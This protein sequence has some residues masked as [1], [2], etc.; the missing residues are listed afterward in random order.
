M[1]ENYNLEELRTLHEIA[2]VVSRSAELKDQLQQTLD[3]LSSR[4]G[5]ERGMVSVLD[6]QTGEAW[7]DVARG[8][9][10]ERGTIRYRP[11]EGITGK[12]AQSGR[13]MGIANLGDEALFLDRTGARRSLNR[14]ELAFLCV[15]IF[16]QGRSVGVLSA[17]KLARRVEDLDKEVEIL[18]AVA[19]LLGK[20][21]HFR[22]VEEENSRLRRMLAEARRPT[23]NII[24]RSKVIQEVLRAIDQVA[25]TNTTVLISGETGTGKELVARAIH[26][27]SR[28]AKGPLVQVNCAAMPDTLLES[29][30]FGHEK[31]AFTG[32]V[33]RR[34]GRFEE[35]QGG[36]IFLDEVGELS[37]IAQAKLLRVLQEREFQP[38]G[39]SRTVKVDVRVITAS[40][41]DLEKEV[42][43]G[44][45]RSDL[46]YRLNVFPIFLP[47]LRERGPDILL[48]ADYFVLKYARELDKDVKRI[49]TSAIDMLMCYHWPGNVRELENCI[50]RAV[51]LAG[52][53]AVDSWHLPPTLQMKPVG[54]QNVSRGKLEALVSAFE[55]DLITDAL[56]DVRGNQ[57]QAARLLGTTK[58][59]VQYKVEKYG[60]DPRRFRV[61]APA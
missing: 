1:S 12:V 57:S 22:A 2:R 55:R 38:L 28:R 59:I 44:T 51:L 37:P 50:E 46:Y 16:Y 49:T 60:I 19:E 39:S 13:P 45:F 61:K 14:E 17:D 27:N 11:G 35:A 47:P 29:E 21:V 18:S 7:L 9:D 15:P 54:M 36:T 48:L 40:N 20:V 23:T 30:L 32:A 43:L 5:M 25:D 24:G 31:G 52:G 10:V 42:A 8:V 4:L 33:T 53:N 41:K 6:L 56:K 3:I 34:R 26:D 58:R